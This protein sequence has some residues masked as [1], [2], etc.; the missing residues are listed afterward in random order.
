MK[1][2]VKS[3]LCT[4]I[5]AGGLAPIAS[6]QQQKSSSSFSYT[7]DRSRANGGV[8]SMVRDGVSIR[9]EYKGKVTFT[10]D[11]TGIQ[12]LTPGGFLKYR[13]DELAVQVESD[14]QGKLSYAWTDDGRKREWDAQ[15]QQLLAESVRLML[16]RGVGAADRAGQTYQKGGAAAVLANVPTL[17]EG[18]VRGIYLDYLLV[19]ASLSAGELAE[20][21]KQI[22]A[23][24]SDHEKANL[25]HKFTRQQLQAPEV[26]KA[27]L[28][29]VATIDSDFEQARILKKVLQEGSLGAPLL[30]EA[31]RIAADIDSDFEKSQVLKTA[32]ASELSETSLGA[33]LELVKCIGSDFEKSQA[34]KL[35]LAND[36]V[37]EAI[38]NDAL[39][40]VGSLSSD[41]E[42]SSLLKEFLANGAASRNFAKV[43]GLVA[44][45]S[46][47][48]EQ[49]QLLKAL[50]VAEDKTD[51][52]WVALL[53]AVGRLGSDLE[54]VNV[55]VKI[56]Q[57]MP[58]AATVRD[59]YAKAAKSIG[60]DH[61][62]GRAMRALE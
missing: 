18:H 2:S 30:V 25:L 34:L 41:F 6:A 52:Q 39:D 50:A 55:L 19:N 12:A 32:F 44:T 7:Y 20:V 35:L 31:L 26:G 51:E 5:I 28:A 49:A 1:F 24:E 23:L 9:L 58:Q 36:Q 38:R 8:L 17:P 22:A 3:W 37:P 45:I 53:Q 4:A 15:G 27:F 21:A 47:D 61:E 46:S 54:K 33:A 48:F 57:A 40:L 60:S 56:A 14:H 29:A 59:A 16:D 13:R 62:Y 42:K 43:L 11:E 10:D